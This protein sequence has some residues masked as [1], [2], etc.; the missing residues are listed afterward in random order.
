MRFICTVLLMGLSASGISFG[1][2]APDKPIEDIWYTAFARD[3]EGR[4]Q[5]IGYLHL[6]TQS[7]GEN[8][9]KLVRGTREL[10]LTIKRDGQLAQLKAENGTEETDSGEV[11]GVFMRHWLAQKQVLSM[12]GKLDESKNKMNLRIESAVKNEFSIPWDG[13]VIGVSAEA[14]MLRVK[15]FSAGDKLT[16]RIF[17]PT[18]SSVATVRVTVKEIE[19]ILLPRGGK[20]KLLRAE[21]VPD[22]IMNVQMPTSTIWFDPETLEPV[23]NRCEMPDFGSLTFLRSTQAVAMGPLGV[24]PDLTKLQTIRLPRAIS[25]DVHGLG[26]ITYV[27]TVGTDADPAKLIKT[28]DRQTIEK[29]NGKTFELVVEARRTPK[30]LAKPAEAA[31]EFLK[32]NYFL[33][34]DDENV[35]NLAARAVGTLQDPWAKAKAIERWVR[36]NMKAVNYSEAMATSDHV[37][38][39]LA[40]DCS[41]YSMLAAAMCKAQ[42]IPARTAIGLVYINDPAY[43]GACARLPYVDGGLCEG[44]MA[45]P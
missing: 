13:K 27:I 36:A 20:K 40:G 26:S 41:E 30:V 45:R 11:V 32:S 5:Q 23:M 22:Q 6:Y 19:E 35:K 24:V 31:D 9:Q 15:K 7:V 1:Q 2:A 33:N 44:S 39:T 25:G 16:Y 37:A 14:M 42:G 21:L 29:L 17:E 28:D 8:G 12:T 34:S 10:R 18:F 3:R 43:G 38:K 4:D